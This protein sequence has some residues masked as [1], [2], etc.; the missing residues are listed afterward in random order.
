MDRARA[1]LAMVL[2]FHSVEELG[3]LDETSKDLDS[4]KGRFGYSLRG[5]V[6]SA[7]DT[8]LSHTVVR[9]SALCLYTV[10]DG[11]LDWAMTP[12]TFNREYFVHVTTENFVDWRGVTRRPM[13]LD[14]IKPSSD[15]SQR[16]CC[17]ILLDNASIHK[18]DEFVARV[19]GRG[20]IV[21]FIPPYCHFLSPLDNGAFGALVQWLKK[22]S[23][24]QYVQSVGIE[25]GLE[26]A[27]HDLNSD[28]GRLA[29]Y[30]F[31]NC[32]YM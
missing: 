11:F 17:C 27:F 20:G 4:L 1:W 26:D 30:C 19:V 22:D 28:G 6:C 12:G 10:Q 2:T 16:K 3:V 13:L 5:T 24:Y 15:P 25:Q 21:R 8:F 14:H 7:H 23:H 9:T 18:S 31:R 32:E 29:R